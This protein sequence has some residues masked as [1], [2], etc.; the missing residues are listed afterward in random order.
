[1]V[2]RGSNACG[3]FASPSVAAS[4][5]RRR[6]AICN[7]NSTALAS[8]Q[9]RTTRSSRS[10][11]KELAPNVGERG[12]SRRRQPTASLAIGQQRPGPPLTLLST[13]PGELLLLRRCDVGLIASCEGGAC[14]PL[15]SNVSFFASCVVAV[16][17]KANDFEGKSKSA[18]LCPQFLYFSLTRCCRC[19]RI[20]SVI[21]G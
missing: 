11:G 2:R 21:V 9:A 20:T 14:A 5:A 16:Q 6:I 4:A 18:Q 3:K 1:M 19:F 15:S 17:R 8:L 7:G 12:R 13:F 10:T